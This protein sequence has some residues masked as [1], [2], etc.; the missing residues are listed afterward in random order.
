MFEIQKVNNTGISYTK[1]AKPSPAATKA[2]SSSAIPQDFAKVSAANLKAYVPSFAGLGKNKIEKSKQAQMKAIK[3]KLDADTK[4]LFE[5]LK[6]SGV[7]DN[8]DS[9]DGSSV[10]DNLAKIAKEPR[11]TGLS[12]SQI[13][14]DV[15][16]AL[17]NPFSITQKFGDIPDNVEKEYEKT[18]GE[19]FPQDAKH[20]ISS[21]C[22]A[23][24]NEF[25]L[26]Y[27][28]P[29]EFAR[30]AEG[31]SS[32]EYKVTKKLKMSNIA[33][34]KTVQCINDLNRF[35]TNS[36]IYSDWDSFDI[37]I[38]PDRNAIVRARV[39][40][41][42]KDPGERS[43]VDVLIQSALLNLGSQSTYNAITDI[44]TGDL[45]SEPTGLNEEE[46]NFV[47]TI[48]FEKPKISVVYQ[49]I[50]Q[51]G[52]LKGS[53]CEMSE[54]KQH[55]L[56]SLNLGQ[57]III[58]YIHLDP[59]NQVIGGHEITIIGY[60]EDDNGNGYFVCNDTD[61]DK[62][63]AILIPE[64]DLLPLI[65]HA[66][67]PEEALNPNDIYEEPWRDILNTFQSA[68]SQK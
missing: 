11:I 45:N 39:Q 50:D 61:D 52:Y 7:L 16:I 59:N 21:G 31:L 27:S 35:N 57:S 48:V 24:S 54:L 42:Y 8:A 25:T 30:F 12:N 33:K 63:E 19:E 34:G 43:V 23:A 56:N 10:L 26:A 13:L 17:A 66:G 47:E 46:K 14:K 18:I 28:R 2:N 6:K 36:K 62:D 60:N 3:S 9:N 49:D 68:I 1:A 15:I 55:L 58:G 29:A 53:R 32:P 4:A 44:R 5:E 22:V 40:S 65:H 37:D 64:K 38:Y 41:S 20:V 51:N 67:I